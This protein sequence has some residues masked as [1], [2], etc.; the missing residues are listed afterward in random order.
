MKTLT[1]VVNAVGDP[2]AIIVQTVCQ[3]VTVGEDESVASYPTTEFNVRFPTIADTPRRLGIGKTY[4]FR[5]ENYWKPGD[6]CGYVDVPTG[7][8]LF[9][10]DEGD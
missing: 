4:T 1:L 5:R 10:Q 9:F 3:R 6:I 8:T 7:S 2:E